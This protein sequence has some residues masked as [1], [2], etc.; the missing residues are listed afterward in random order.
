[1]NAAARAMGYPLHYVR[2]MYVLGEI[3]IVGGMCGVVEGSCQYSMLM[4]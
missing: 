4:K 2:G 1:M 3:L